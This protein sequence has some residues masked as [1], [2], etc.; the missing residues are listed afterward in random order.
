V[1]DPAARPTTDDLLMRLQYH[2]RDDGM[3]TQ[4]PGFW[5]PAWQTV[6]MPGGYEPVPSGYEPVPGDYEPDPAAATAA[7]E[8]APPPPRQGFRG[9]AVAGWATAIAGLA[10]LCVIGGL[11]VPR[12]IAGPP[13][14]SAPSD[15][16]PGATGHGHGA[17]PHTA[18]ASGPAALGD[19]IP[20]RFAGTWNGEAR[21]A[22]GVIRHWA[23]T[24]VLPQGGTMGTFT[25]P[26]I[27]CRATVTVA[28]VTRAR[29]LLNE[30]VDSNPSGNCAASGVISLNR[31]G[32]ARV[33]MLWEDSGDPAN[34]ATG[35]LIRA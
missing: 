7:A 12:L 4:P 16:P 14:V 32:V 21:Q 17:S 18:H 34:V 31:A 26:S 3:A 29:I 33:K 1:K 9:R 35:F 15:S 20:A 23:A 24:L 11:L 28:Q 2:A 27:P 8:M 13:A 19:A 5:Q 25:I 22:D 6:P 30:T 10:A